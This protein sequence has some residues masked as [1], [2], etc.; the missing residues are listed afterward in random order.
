MIAVVLLSAT[1]TV[2]TS[3]N[4]AIDLECVGVFPE[5]ASTFFRFYVDWDREKTV[6]ALRCCGSAD[7]HSGSNN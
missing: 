5:T 3:S 4:V 7:F 2:N 1:A 6:L